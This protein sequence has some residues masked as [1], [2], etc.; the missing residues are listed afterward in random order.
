MS[1][2]GFDGGEER[3]NGGFWMMKGWVAMKKT[4]EMD[5]CGAEG[6][7]M[8]DEG[9]VRERGT[10]GEAFQRRRNVSSFCFLFLTF[11]GVFIPER[12]KCQWV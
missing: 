5:E 4:M 8:V 7:L 9:L 12:E 6:L 3:V 11:V 10:N 1:D 2:E